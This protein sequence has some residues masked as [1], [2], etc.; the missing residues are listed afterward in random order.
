MKS[1]RE[2]LLTLTAGLV[3]ATVIIMPVLAEEPFGVITHV[4]LESKKVTLLT[5]GGET[6]ELEITDSTEIVTGKGE[7]VDLEAVAK[8]VAKAIEDGKKGVFARVTHE[9]KVASRISVGLPKEQ[10]A[11]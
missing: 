5:K 10:K 1:R 9:K 11:K 8:A 3:A 4:D 7:K 6:L 2:V